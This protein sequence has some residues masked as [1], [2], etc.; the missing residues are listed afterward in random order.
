MKTGYR[1]RFNLGKGEHF[2]HW[3]V[4]S[5]QT[6]TVQYY[7]PDLYELFMTD[8]TLKNQKKTAQKI[9]D[10]ENKSVCAWIDCKSITVFEVY[11]SYSE[12]AEESRLTYNPR[13]APNWQ[14]HEGNNMDKTSH[15][16]LYTS[17]KAVGVFPVGVGV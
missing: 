16:H 9:H 6:G 3:Q 17:Q 5:H 10:G 11:K 2:M 14:D 7:N 12:V 1:V 15:K 8:A 13:V 4:K